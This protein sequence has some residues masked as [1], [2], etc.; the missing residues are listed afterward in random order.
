MPIQTMS[1]KYS[2]SGIAYA[3]RFG[4]RKKRERL[5]RGSSTHEGVL[6]A[7]MPALTSEA[8][9][10]RLIAQ[11]IDIVDII[12]SSKTGNKS[13]IVITSPAGVV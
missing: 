3:S 9:I 10:A 6:E 5:H 1:G 11:V 12:S 13:A 7:R 4:S 8:D 2:N